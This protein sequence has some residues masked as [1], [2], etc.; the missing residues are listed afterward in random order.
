[1]STYLHF[2]LNSFSY[3]GSHSQSKVILDVCI[4]FID[5]VWTEVCNKIRSVRKF[6]SYLQLC[7]SNYGYGFLKNVLKTGICLVDTQSSLNLEYV[8]LWYTELMQH[9]I[10]W[11]SSC[12]HKELEER[13]SYGI[14]NLIGTE[15]MESTAGSFKELWEGGGQNTE[16]T[17]Y[18]PATLQDIL[19]MC[20]STS[21]NLPPILLEFWLEFLSYILHLRG[22]WSGSGHTLLQVSV[23]LQREH[24]GWDKSIYQTHIPVK[25]SNWS[26]ISL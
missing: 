3:K 18:S 4:T 22:N 10:N 14:R 26:A 6:F 21:H 17:L 2:S 23:W 19:F 5:Q 7:I 25:S 9:L 16:K 24:K 1:M 13:S 11:S 20:W 15:N 8:C 12:D